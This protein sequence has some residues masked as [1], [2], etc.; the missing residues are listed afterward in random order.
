MRDKQIWP[1]LEEVLSTSNDESYLEIPNYEH[2]YEIFGYS[3]G[4]SL[5]NILFIWEKRYKFEKNVK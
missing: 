2:I 4:K 1:P 5:W 3:H